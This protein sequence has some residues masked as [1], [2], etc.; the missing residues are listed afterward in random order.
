LG[1]TKAPLPSP[2]A[3]A[4]KAKLERDVQK[5]LD[6]A[7]REHEEAMDA[8]VR[9]RDQLRYERESY[10][11]RHPPSAPFDPSDHESLFQRH[12]QTS[13]MPIPTSTST[14]A[15]PFTNLQS[16][17]QNQ[18]H[19]AENTPTA[20]IVERNPVKIH[21]KS[22]LNDHP[23]VNLN[24]AYQGNNNIDSLIFNNFY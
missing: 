24:T 10:Q 8:L 7:Y 18:P 20:E 9:E 16:V 6:Q 23:N 1:K 14:T 22:N 5:A 17:Q 2:A 3:E 12:F 11:S 13:P 4:Y 19:L 15:P 21:E